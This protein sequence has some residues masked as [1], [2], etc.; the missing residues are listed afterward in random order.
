[1]N[2]TFAALLMFGMLFPTMAMAQSKSSIV[3]LMTGAYA[4]GEG[5][6]MQQRPPLS[7]SRIRVSLP[8][9]PPGQ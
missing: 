5:A 3:P 8:I 6:A 2:K 9:K 7:I 4:P 1:M